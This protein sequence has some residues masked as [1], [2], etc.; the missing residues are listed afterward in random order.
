MHTAY[1]REQF[2]QA[3]SALG[4]DI[5]YGGILSLGQP[6]DQQACIKERIGLGVTDTSWDC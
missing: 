6:N 4:F 5:A 1:L 3:W 2:L